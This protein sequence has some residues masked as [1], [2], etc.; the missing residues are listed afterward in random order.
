MASA[1]GA[2]L[3]PLASKSAAASDDTTR[4]SA[5]SQAAALGGNQHINISSPGTAAAAPAEGSGVGSGGKLGAGFSPTGDNDPGQVA[6]TASA[7]G[8]AGIPGAAETGVTTTATA[9]STRNRKPNALGSRG[10]FSTMNRVVKSFPRNSNGCGES[11]LVG[12]EERAAAAAV[13]IS[14]EGQQQ[15]AGAVPQQELTPTQAA[16]AA[17]DNKLEGLLNVGRILREKSGWE[18]PHGFPRGTPVWDNTEGVV[19]SGGTGGCDRV[20]DAGAGIGVGGGVRV[21]RRSSSSGGGLGDVACD[22]DVGRAVMGWVSGFCENET[23]FPAADSEEGIR[24]G[25]LLARHIVRDGDAGL[26][27]TR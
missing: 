17:A 12:A 25:R 5:G 18:C 11:L 4:L 16:V 15:G 9:S 27:G 19:G 22:E 3:D 13:A 7:A 2:N 21:S 26:I 1:V 10:R 20:D 23:G 14:P 8:A 6:D 24:L